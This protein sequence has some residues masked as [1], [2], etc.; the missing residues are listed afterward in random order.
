MIELPECAIPQLQADRK[1]KFTRK[2]RV[3]GAGRYYQQIEHAVC[4][5]PGSHVHGSISGHTTLRSANAC[6]VQIRG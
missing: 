4:I 2:K 5:Y 1:Q 6:I 3:L